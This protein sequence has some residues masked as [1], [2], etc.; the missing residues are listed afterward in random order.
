VCNRFLGFIAAWLFA[1]SCFAQSVP[2]PGD[3]TGMW[4][5]AGDPGWGITFAQQDNVAFATLFV[6]DASGAPAWYVASRLVPRVPSVNSCGVTAL[7]GTLYRTQWPNFASV[8]QDRGNLQVAAV[9]SLTFYAATDPGC[10]VNTGQLLYT[11]GNVSN[12]VQV[13]RQTWASNQ[14]RLYGQFVGGLHFGELLPTPCP[15]INPAFLPVSGRQL[16]IRGSPDLSAD[17]AR[18]IR[19]VWGTGIDTVCEVRGTYLQAGQLGAVTGTLSCGPLG[20]ALA[21]VGAIRLSSLYISDQGFVG[22]AVL[23]VNTCRYRG[24]IS[25]A[26]DLDAR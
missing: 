4:F 19:L 12:I 7:E 3:V 2:F 14:A 24:A 6:Y 13:T 15:D 10:D 16:S 26:K 21:P 17:N 9:G 20:S 11:I 18:G 22:D 1:I 5:D 8:T 23:D 25:G